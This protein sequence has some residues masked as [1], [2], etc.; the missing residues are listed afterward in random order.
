MKYQIKQYSEK[1]FSAQVKNDWFGSWESI[2][3][4][5]PVFTWTLSESVKKHT[6]VETFIEAEN[7]VKRHKDWIESKKKYPKFFKI[8]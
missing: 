5:N 6:I 3:R 2:D 7:I 8:K 4:D 1:Q